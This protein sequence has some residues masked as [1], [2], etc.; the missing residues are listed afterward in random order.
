MGASFTLALGCRLRLAG[1][2]G[3]ALLSERA[4]AER[5]AVIRAGLAL[6]RGGFTL[7]RAAR[8]EAFFLGFFEFLGIPITRLKPQRLTPSRTEI[9]C[10]NA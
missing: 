3:F 6:A 4:D 8:A 2:R 1:G 7:G 5:L 10:S 9:Q